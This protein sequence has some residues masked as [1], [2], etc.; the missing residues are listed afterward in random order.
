MAA[1][2]AFRPSQHQSAFVSQR[3]AAARPK[4]SGFTL[5]ELLIVVAIIAILAAI[6]VV[7]FKLAHDRA[8]QSADAANLHTIATALQTYVVDHNVLPPADREAGPFPSH[9]PEFTQVM[10][11][12]AAGG[13]HDGLPW[14]LVEQGYISDPK[15]L[16][17]PKYLKLYSGGQTHRGG[18]PRYHNF[19]YAYNAAAVSS[20]G[21]G[22]HGVM[23]GEVWIVRDLY[24]PA[25]AGWW[26]E[27]APEYPGDYEYPWGEDNQFEFALYSDM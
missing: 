22:A 24:I 4:R 14:L 17:C 10:N 16:F 12:P 3:S 13:S 1:C 11:G 19:R 8:L 23:T 26:A 15:T 25:E 6:A 18:W 21:A 9:G 27:A 2:G 5:I 7:N 20:G